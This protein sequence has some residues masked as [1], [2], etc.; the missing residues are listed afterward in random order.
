MIT[1]VS[2][3]DSEV[4]G[5]IKNDIFKSIKKHYAV[6][7]FSS[8]KITSTDA[9]CNITILDGGYSSGAVRKVLRVRGTH[10]YKTTVMKAI[11]GIDYING[12]FDSINIF[13]ECIK[14]LNLDKN[15]T[16]LETNECESWAINESD[17]FDE[18][19]EI[20]T[21]IIGMSKEDRD[22]LIASII[23]TGDSLELV[24]KDGKIIEIFSKYGKPGLDILKMILEF[25]L[26]KEV[27]EILSGYFK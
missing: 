12:F 24:L 20:F 2:H 21:H 27:L 7:A 17:I 10:V 23:G 16:V 9:L 8:S 5:E 22:L 15:I 19:P 11:N 1:K 13:N 4:F 25:G 18:H 3:S 6:D 14:T 26:L